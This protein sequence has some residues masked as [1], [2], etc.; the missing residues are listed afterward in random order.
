MKPDSEEEQL[1]LTKQITSLT[2][3]MIEANIGSNPVITTDKIK[4][5]VQNL[6]TSQP[7]TV[8]TLNDVSIKIPAGVTESAGTT[9][10]AAAEYSA[11]S[12][13]GKSSPN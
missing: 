9:H 4:I 2:E 12:Y 10:V 3:K 1:E 7:A 5:A 11:V 13:P 8:V 6:V